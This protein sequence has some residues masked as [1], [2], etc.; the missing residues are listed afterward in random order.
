MSNWHEWGNRNAR[1]AAWSMAVAAVFWLAETWYFGWN[2][3]AQ[4]QAEVVCDTIAVAFFAYGFG[5]FVV[6]SAA[7]SRADK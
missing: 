5:G 1:D 7:A 6:A 4:S 3:M 2:W